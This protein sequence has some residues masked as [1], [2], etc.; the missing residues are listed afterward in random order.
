MTQ[1][2]RNLDEEKFKLEL[3]KDRINDVN[4]DEFINSILN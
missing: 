1:I 2:K 4:V 3:E